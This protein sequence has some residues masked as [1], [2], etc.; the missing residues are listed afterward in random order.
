MDYLAQEFLLHTLAYAKQFLTNNGMHANPIV[1][2][3]ET[4]KKLA[5]YW[6]LKPKIV[7]L[8]IP[9]ARQSHYWYVLFYC[10]SVIAISK[11]ALKNPTDTKIIALRILRPSTLRKY[12]LLP[13]TY[14]KFMQ[15]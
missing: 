8:F 12:I 10:H 15:S 3:L 13:E 11:T 14:L 6:T 7:N 9:M 1:L 2:A 4:E 5:G